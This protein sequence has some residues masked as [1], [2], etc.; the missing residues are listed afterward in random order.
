M[1][2]LGAPPELVEK[3]RRRQEE[4]AHFQ[5]LPENWPAVELFQVVNTQWERTA[6]GQPLD[7][8]WQAVDVILRRLGLDPTPTD[9]RKLMIMGRHAAAEQRKEQ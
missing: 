3:E 7:L 6:S 9:F 2:A 4:P 8:N 5:V 1:E